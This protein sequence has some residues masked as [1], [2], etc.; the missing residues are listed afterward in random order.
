LA[1]AAGALADPRGGF[2]KGTPVAWASTAEVAA[3]KAAA[4]MKRRFIGRF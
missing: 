2:I 1:A 3:L 4:R